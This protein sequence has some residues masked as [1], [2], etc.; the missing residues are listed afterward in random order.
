M[1]I[2][3]SV[4]LRWRIIWMV[5][6]KKKGIDE[7]SELCCISKQTIRRYIRKFKQTGEVK[8]SDYRHGPCKMLNNHEQLALLRIIQYP[9]LYLHE[10]QSRLLN[11]VGKSVSIATI[12]QTLQYMGCTRQA[13]KHVASQRSDEERAR[14]MAEISMYDPTMIIW[15]DETGCDKRHSTRKWSYS[16]R[17]LTPQDHR[18]LARGKRYSAITSMSAEGILDVYL[19]EGTVNG[20]KFEE[21]I[22][23]SLLPVLNPFNWSNKHS[24]VVMDNASIH[25]IDKIHDLIETRA[26]AKLIYLPPYSPDLNPV[27]EVFSQVKSIMKENDLLFQVSDIPR[28]L[29]LTAFSMVTNENCLNYIKHSGY[30]D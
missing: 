17:G 21:F 3:Y 10:I 16:I 22:E 8:P 29:L 28:I 6:V 26:N 23:F 18:L 19:A 7:V 25:H 11:D 14:Y 20:T 5:L 12:C 15:I 13:M 27:E 2:S 24:V 9:G 4:D 30:Y 1:P